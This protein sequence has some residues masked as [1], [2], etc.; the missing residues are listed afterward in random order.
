MHPAH[1]NFFKNSMCKFKNQGHN[2]FVTVLDRGELYKIVEKELG[3]FNI[4]IVGKHKG[5]KLSII[6]SA[7]FFRFFE[8]FLYLFKIRPDVGFSVGSFILGSNLKMRGVKNYQ[9]DDDPERSINVFLEKLTSTRLFFP[10]IYSSKSKKVTQINTLKE[11]AYLSP[12][13]F[14]PDENVLIELGL[15]KKSYIF[16][17]EVSSG[18]L[19]YYNQEEGKLSIIASKLPENYK[20]VLS[21]ENKNK[22]Y[23]YPMNWIL[24]SEPVSD[25]H[26]IMYY[27][28]MVISSGDSMAREGAMLGVPSIY[29]GIR[30][31]KANKI[32]EEKNIL[33]HEQFDILTKLN[34]IVENKAFLL[35]QDSFRQKLQNEWID[36]NELILN[37]ASL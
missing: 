8:M 26:S 16:I 20:V 30:S 32:L 10:M 35:E 31:M 5:T 36:V 4:K 37:L 14:T 6:F 15:N 9:F 21:L 29:C 28:R 18:S 17:R 33:F 19:N 12:K 24:L 23:L 11:W 27:S 22:K 3:D 34:T 13:Y 7:N 1:I 25:I 2:V